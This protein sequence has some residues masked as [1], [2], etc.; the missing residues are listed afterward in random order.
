[1][2]VLLVTPAYPEPDQ[3]VYLGIQRLAEGLTA[4]LQHEGVEM[5]VATTF[6]G[7]TNA[8]EVTTT[9]SGIAVRRYADTSQRYGRLGRLASAD[10]Y[11]FGRAIAN[12][13]ELLD[14]VDV[15]HSLME[16]GIERRVNTPLVS[17]HHHWGNLESAMD[18][19]TYPGHKLLKRFAYRYADAITVPSNHS[20]QDLERRLWGRHSPIRVIPHGVDSEKFRPAQTGRNL[21]GGIRILYAGPFERRKRLPDLIEAMGQLRDHGLMFQATLVGDGELFEEVADQVHEFDLSDQ[22][23]LPGV[24]SDR[25]LLSL[26]QQSDVFVLPSIQEG[27]GQVILEAMATRTPPVVVDLPPMNQIVPFSELIVEPRDATSIATAI[28]RLVREGMLESLATK[29][30]RHAENH[31][32]RAVTEQYISLYEELTAR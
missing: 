21:T 29:C 8:P 27:F 9:D 10:F 1:M 14:V 15:V 31:D 32:W 12:D 5:T 28:E 3:G 17:S 13:H 24:V 11:T 20:K 30:R 26:Y 2:N 25:E 23:S 22:V 4:G 6:W 18:L 16:L 7:H 19:L